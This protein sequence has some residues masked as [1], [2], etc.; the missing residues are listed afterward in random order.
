MNTIGKARE[1]Y[2]AAAKAISELGTFPRIKIGCVAV[3]KHKIISSGFNSCKTSPIQKKYNAYRFSANTPHYLHAEV[4]CL[5]PLIGRKDIDFKNVELFLYRENAKHELAL[6]RSCPSC[7][8][9]ISD[10]GIRYINYT[11]DNGYCLER[12]IS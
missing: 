6:S 4:S 12:I 1:A 9:L 10:L 3:Y 11:T 8:R 5:K 2:F 7:M